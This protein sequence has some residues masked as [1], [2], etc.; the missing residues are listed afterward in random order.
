MSTSLPDSSLITEP[1]KT[2]G[3]IFIS[4]RGVCGEDD[5]RYPSLKKIRLLGGKVGINQIEK[6]RSALEIGSPLA[7]AAVLLE[8]NE[9]RDINISQIVPLQDLIKNLRDYFIGDN[10]VDVPS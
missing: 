9:G 5:F 4:T 3:M 1:A 7:H 8:V 10:S 2:A 6:S